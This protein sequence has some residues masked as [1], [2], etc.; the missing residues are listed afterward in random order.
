LN[1]HD[2]DTP[3]QDKT[4]YSVH[5][6]QLTPYAPALY[7]EG[8]AV[9]PIPSIDPRE[10]EV[11]DLAPLYHDDRQLIWFSHLASRIRFIIRGE[12][13]RDR[14]PI[15]FDQDRFDNG[16]VKRREVAIKVNQF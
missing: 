13:D 16:V 4:F 7:A 9:N 6:F 15:P 1:L 12:A 5:E 3:G 10:S 11:T 14:W 2:L 8:Q